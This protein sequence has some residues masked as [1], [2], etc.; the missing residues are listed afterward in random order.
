MEFVS[1]IFHCMA[2]FQAPYK[3]VLVA[4][5]EFA[6]QSN[7]NKLCCEIKKIF[8][9]QFDNLPGFCLLYACLCGNSKK[10]IPIGVLSVSI[11]TGGVFSAEG[12]AVG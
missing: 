5:Y 4:L 9:R 11:D 3:A 2:A 10:V 12:T 7:N 1:K 8:D 6:V